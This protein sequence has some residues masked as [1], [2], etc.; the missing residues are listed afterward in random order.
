M[1]AF[2]IHP[3][4]GL[5]WLC[6]GSLFFFSMEFWFTLSKIA[7]IYFFGEPYTQDE[8]L[9]LYLTCYLG[10]IGAFLWLLKLYFAPNKLLIDPQNGTITR[11]RTPFLKPQRI[12]GPMED[13]QVEFLFFREEE[14]EKKIFKVLVL[15]LDSY[16]EAIV[17]ADMKRMKVDELTDCLYQLEPRFAAFRTE[18]E[19]G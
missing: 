2:R 9:P 5:A 14:R 3:P 15:R 17:P 19:K 7:V 12:H 18:I 6:A 11:E 4:T 13:W 8:M 1:I 16:K 10:T